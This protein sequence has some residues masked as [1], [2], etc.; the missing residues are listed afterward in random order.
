MEPWVIWL[1]ISIILIVMELLFSGFVLL[2]FG[3]AAFLTSLITLSGIRI[4]FQILSFILLTVISFITIRPFFLKHMKPL[5]GNS[6][7]NVYAL[8]GKEAILTSTISKGGSG[9]LK[10]RGDEWTALSENNSAIEAGNKVLIL[11]IDGNK[12]IVKNIKQGE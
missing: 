1:I 9:K 2:C 5:G 4:E 10:I 12:L 7:T 6:E 8:I 3:S 11:K